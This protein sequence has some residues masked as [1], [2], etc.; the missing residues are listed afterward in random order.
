MDA[1]FL[2]VKW[3]Q[4]V[5][6]PTVNGELRSEFKCFREFVFFLQKRELSII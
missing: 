6:S 4:V 3:G 1:W 2:V 5:K